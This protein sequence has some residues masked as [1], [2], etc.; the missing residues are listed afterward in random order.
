MAPALTISTGDFDTHFDKETDQVTKDDLLTVDGYNTRI[1]AYP[2]FLPT[3][4]PNEKYP[5]LKYFKHVHPGLRADPTFLSFF[6]LRITG[7]QLSQL[8]DKGKDE[9]ALLVAQRGVVVFREQIFEDHGPKF[10]VETNAILWHSDVSYELQPPGTTFFTILDGPE[11]R[12][13]TI[14]AV[15]QEAYARLFPKAP[16]S[17]IHPLIRTHPVTGKKG[18]FLNRP[19][20]RRIVEL[21]EQ[22]SDYLLNFLYTHIEQSHD[23]HRLDNRRVFHSVVIDWDEAVSRH[24]FRIAPQAERPVEDLYLYSD[25]DE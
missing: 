23:L 2:E 15:T 7:V 17:H 21:K 10:A 25:L 14:F 13:E 5:P 22:E 11:A 12:G 6:T 1:T 24:A 4:N 3:W 18:I 19:F 16:V 9:L 20:V 8:D